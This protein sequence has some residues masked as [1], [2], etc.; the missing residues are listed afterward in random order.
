M[1]KTLLALGLALGLVLNPAATK[2][3]QELNALETTENV[4]L[5]TI[6]I[7]AEIIAKV[8]LYKVLLKTFYGLL[9]PE[10]ITEKN[11]KTTLTQGLKVCALIV[12]SSFTSGLMHGSTSSASS[13][14]DYR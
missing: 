11:V 4:V 13:I 10:A 1:K 2:P 6:A 5:E 9:Y 14:Q 7:S 12:F 8:N 3:T